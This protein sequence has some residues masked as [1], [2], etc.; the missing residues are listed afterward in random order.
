MNEERE[1]QGPAHVRESRAMQRPGRSASSSRASPRSAVSISFA[2]ILLAQRAHATSI[3][4][5]KTLK[6]LEAAGFKVNPSIAAWRKTWRQVWTFIQ[7]WEEKRDTLPYEIDGVVIKVDRTALQDE[8]GFT[9]KAPRWAIAYK[10]AARAGVTQI[11]DILVQ[12][13]RTGKL[14]PVAALKPVADRRHHGTARHAA[15]HGRDRT[16]GREDRR[17]GRG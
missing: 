7:E 11:E 1:K 14:T 15:Q 17:L 6:A 10:Y 4:S 13:G 16:A 5:P 9:G 3:A 2:Y 12:V 8:L